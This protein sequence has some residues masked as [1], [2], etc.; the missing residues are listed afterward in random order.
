MKFRENIKTTSKSLSSENGIELNEHVK[1]TKTIERDGKK[2]CFD[3]HPHLK[4]DIDF[5][6]KLYG[7]ESHTCIVR[8]MPFD[9]NAD[10][11]KMRIDRN[12][13]M[14]YVEEKEPEQLDDGLLREMFPNMFGD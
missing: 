6:F 7:R 2:F 5:Y 8:Q 11:M 12:F 3:G 10:D 4:K 14:F 1:W 9:K 13:C